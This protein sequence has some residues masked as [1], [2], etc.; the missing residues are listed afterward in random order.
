M[1]SV[2][3]RTA[4][5]NDM[6]RWVT[7]AQFGEHPKYLH[8]VIINDDEDMLE[9]AKQM[10]LLAHFPTFN[11]KNPNTCTRISILGK[12]DET[13]LWEKTFGNLQ[14]SQ[15]KDH[16][17][18]WIEVPLDVLVEYEPVDVNKESEV[19]SWIEKRKKES[20]YHL[21]DYDKEYIINKSKSNKNPFSIDREM[22]AMRANSVYEA[23]QT[24]DIIRANDIKNVDEFDT[25]IKSFLK[26]NVADVQSSWEKLN[27][28]LLEESNRCLADS[29]C[30]RWRIL[31]EIRKIDR[32]QDKDHKEKSIFDILKCHLEEMSCSE[33][34]RWNVEKLINGF[35]PYTKMEVIED[36]NL[37]GPERSRLISYLKKNN[38]I[39]AHIDLCSYSRLR[40]VDLE[41]IKY[42]SF[43]L[44]AM[45]KYW[46]ETILS[47]IHK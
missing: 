13:A 19:K 2:E 28:V 33:H 25:P 18:G 7:P 15:I 5:L 45:V 3:I 4:L 46:E 26:M 36:E 43:L 32:E 44:L 10:A 11:E 9:V 6:N 38:A 24:F 22:L 47:L 39:L 21:V 37:C 23:S 40:R 29:I 14:K 34:A 20:M 35:R 12:K 42:D 30:V 27:D 8:V 31:E 1:T 16:P 17:D 41:S